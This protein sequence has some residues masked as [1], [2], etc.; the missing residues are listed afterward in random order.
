MATYGNQYFTEEIFSTDY[1]SLA[2]AIIEA[3]APKHIVEVGCGPGHLT[4]SFSALNIKTTAIDGFSVPDFSAYPNIDF[5]KIDLN[6][7]SE[8]STFLN[9]NKGFDL[10]VCTEVAEHLLPESSNYLIEFLTSLAPV[11]VF[12]AA[13]PNQKGTGHINCQNRLFWHKMFAK[14]GFILQDTL[15]KT[16]STNEKLAIW[17]KLNV[18][19]YVKIDHANVNDKFYSDLIERLVENESSV[20]EHY[21]KETDETFKLKSYLNYPGVKQYFNMRNTIKKLLK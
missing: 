14:N 8:M 21:Y 10:V 1:P 13:I 11:V 5:T 16:L 4:K 7:K 17:Y 12:S 2:K 3:Y 20:A 19:D 18:L 9:N 6:N 15:R